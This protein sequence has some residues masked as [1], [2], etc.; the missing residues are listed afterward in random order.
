VPK[1]IGTKFLAQICANFFFKKN[2]WHK[3]F[4]RCNAH[5]GGMWYSV[6]YHED[7]GEVVKQHNVL[8]KKAQNVKP[9]IHEEAAG[10]LG[11]SHN[12]TQGYSRWRQAQTKPE[13]K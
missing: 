9:K 2:N 8:M 1:I 13:K 6:Y 11:T 10:S 12:Q 3:I 5:K 7:A 4:I